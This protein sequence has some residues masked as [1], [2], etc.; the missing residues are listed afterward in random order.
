MVIGKPLHVPRI[1]EPSEEDIRQ[2]LDAFIASMQQIYED[3]KAKAGYPD[4][5]LVVM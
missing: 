5:K 3:H 1:S 2:H 4:S